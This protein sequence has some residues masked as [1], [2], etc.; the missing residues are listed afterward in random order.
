[1][2]ASFGADI[3]FEPVLPSGPFP[4]VFRVFDAQRRHLKS[5]RVFKVGSGLQEWAWE[6]LPRS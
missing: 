1:M 6:E 2:R 4:K 3:S 5:L